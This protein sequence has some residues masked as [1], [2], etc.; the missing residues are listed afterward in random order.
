M[1]AEPSV[2]ILSRGRKGDLDQMLALAKATGWRFEIKTLRFA[3]PEIPLL[4]K[5]LL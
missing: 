3:G 2:W 4:S 5:L 1:A